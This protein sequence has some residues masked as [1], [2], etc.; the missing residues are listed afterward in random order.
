MPAPKHLQEFIRKVN[1]LAS[2]LSNTHMPESKQLTLAAE[3][4]QVVVNK[5]KLDFV[6]HLEEKFKPIAPTGILF[7]SDPS[8]RWNLKGVCVHCLFVA[9]FENLVKVNVNLNSEDDLKKLTHI[10]CASC[11]AAPA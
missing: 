10:K 3:A 11:H 9:P 5:E 6:K 8:S 7:Y 2:K 1:N 4:V